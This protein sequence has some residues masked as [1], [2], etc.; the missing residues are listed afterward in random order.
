MSGAGTI[1][2]RGGDKLI[3]VVTYLFVRVHHKCSETVGDPHNAKRGF[4]FAHMGWLLVR[5]HP[6]VLRAGKRIDMSDLESDPMVMFQHRHYLACYLGAAFLIPT[7]VPWLAW[8]ETLAN[9]YFMAVFRYRLMFQC[10]IHL[11]F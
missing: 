10:S 7:L 11:S 2:R 6:A 3:L 9:A 1:G 4:F 5:K 8:G